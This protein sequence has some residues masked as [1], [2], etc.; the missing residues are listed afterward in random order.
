MADHISPRAPQGPGQSG[1]PVRTEIPRSAGTSYRP[2]IKYYKRMRLGGAYRLS[3]ALR[4]VDESK[5]AARLATSPVR[6]RPVIAG[7]VVTPGERDV[8]PGRSTPAEFGVT[9]LARGKLRGA[10]V[11]LYQDGRLLQEVPLAMKGTR[12]TWTWVLLGLTI[13]VP[14]LFKPVFGRASWT[15]A[16]SPMRGNQAGSLAQRP[17]TPNADARNNGGGR[18]AARGRGPARANV[19]APAPAAKPELKE[20]YGLLG[21]FIL[22]LGKARASLK[23]TSNPGAGNATAPVGRQGGRAR[24]GEAA[25]ARG[26]MRGPGGQQMPMGADPA[27]AQRALAMQQAQARGRGN[28]PEAGNPRPEQSADERKIETIR[29]MRGPVERQVFQTIPVWV[30]PVVSRNVAVGLQDGYDRVATVALG[31]DDAPFYIGVVLLVLTVGSWLI[32]L[33]YPGRRRGQ[34]VTL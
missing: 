30:P 33:G 3:V 16:G 23:A 15:R 8:E 1:G 34:P 28:A 27:M 18:R 19:G 12:Q 20:N 14:L 9:P 11:Q 22:F 29:E 7:A 6:V 21:N 17:E 4:R 10:S 26:G 31:I 24:Q 5:P 13:A 32:H 2:V 25:E